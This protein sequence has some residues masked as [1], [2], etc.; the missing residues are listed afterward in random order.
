MHEMHRELMVVGWSPHKPLT[1]GTAPCPVSLAGSRSESAGI[2]TLKDLQFSI[3]QSLTWIRP[4]FVTLKL[5]SEASIT[6]QYTS[7]S[8]TLS[9]IILWRQRPIFPL[10]RW[11]KSSCTSNH[12]EPVGHFANRSIVPGQLA[13]LAV[14][15]LRLYMPRILGFRML[16]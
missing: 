5:L 9:T 2:R 15:P 10:T 4:Y 11:L 3:L 12:H 1:N 16:R 14:T 7:N 6:L 8:S 13:T